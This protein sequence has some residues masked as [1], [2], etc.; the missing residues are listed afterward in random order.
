[1]Y[2][3]TT[4]YY[5][6]R[7]QMN[8]V[9]LYIMGLHSFQNTIKSGLLVLYVGFVHFVHTLLYISEVET[10]VSSDLSYSVLLHCP[11]V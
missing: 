4:N 5:T 7:T 6:G 3:R 9:V 2:D 10:G 1:M 11:T 8:L